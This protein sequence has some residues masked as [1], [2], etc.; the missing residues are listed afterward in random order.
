M[1]EAHDYFVSIADYTEELRK[2]QRELRHTIR[3]A[4]RY[5]IIIKSKFK[6]SRDYVNEDLHEAANKE[7]LSIT[8]LVVVL[9]VSPVII[10]LVRNAVATIQVSKT[11]T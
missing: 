9:L 5:K 7:A 10:W 11:T 4:A 3:W 8:I 6:I 2:M 1:T